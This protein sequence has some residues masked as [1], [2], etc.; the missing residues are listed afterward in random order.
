MNT[1][2]G[3]LKRMVALITLTL[4]LFAEFSV[5]GIVLVS[6]AIDNFTSNNENVELVAYFE[7]EDGEKSN[8]TQCEIN[9][10]KILK[11]DVTL[12]NNQGY[13]GYFEGKIQISNAN[14]KFIDDSNEE[15]HLSAGET[16]TIEKQICYASIKNFNE[17]Y[18]NK[19]T[20]INLDGKYVNSKG[21]YDIQEIS[22]VKVN[23]ISP[24][25]IDSNFNLEV[26]TNTTYEADNVQD[27]NLN[28]SEN[29][30]ETSKIKRILQILITSGVEDDIYPAKHRKV[31][32]YIPSGV[33]SISIHE[34]TN[35][36]QN[37]SDEN[38][39]VNGEK[40]IIDIDEKEW[41]QNELVVT[42]IF[43]DSRDLKGINI[44]GKLE[45]ILCDET[46]LV[47][48]AEIEIQNEENGMV[49]GQIIEKEE[50]IG[51]GKIYSDD[52]RIYSSAT[53]IR[54]DCANATDKVTI[55]EL[56]ADFIQND[57][58][59]AD[60]NIEFINSVV[61]KKEL[62]NIFGE[63][64]FINIKDQ[65]ENVIESINNNSEA[66]DNECITI[67]YKSGV[68]QISIETSTPKNNGMFYIINNKKIKN[69]ILSR[70]EIAKL[71][72]L[73][74]NVK[75]NNQIVKKDIMLKETETNALVAIEDSNIETM[76]EEKQ[77]LN[78][79]IKLDTQDEMKNLYKKPKVTITM[80]EEIK[81]IVINQAKAL[82]RNGLEIKSANS[83]KN[84]EGKCEIV[85]E[86][87]GEQTN[88]DNNGGLELYLY[89]NVETDNMQQSTTSKILVTYTNELTEEVKFVEKDI[90]FEAKYKIVD[91]P[92]ENIRKNSSN[93]RSINRQTPQGISANITAMREN[94]ELNEEST[95]FEGET[96]KYTVEITNNSDTNYTNLNIKAIQTN[97]KMW[98]YIERK[99]SNPHYGTTVL[100]NYYELT[101][102]NEKTFEKISTFNI[103]DTITLEYEAAADEVENEGLAT[104]GTIIVTADDNSLNEQFITTENEIKEAQLKVW[105]E[106]EESKENTWYAGNTA[107]YDLKIKN[108]KDEKI[109]NA[110]IQLIF[111]SNQIV[112]GNADYIPLGQY[113]NRITFDET[114]KSSN[115]DTIITL[116]IS[117][118]MPN[119]EILIFAHSKMNN[120]EDSQEQDQVTL[121]ARGITEENTY[122]SNKFRRNF[123]RAQNNIE[124]DFEGFKADG[125]KVTEN[126]VFE[127]GDSI[128]LVGT[129]TNNENEDITI[130]IT[131]SLNPGL[132]FEKILIQ[133][134][135]EQAIELTQYATEKTF[136]DTLEI[137]A[138]SQ[139]KI[140][141][142]AKINTD[143]LYDGNVSNQLQIT[144]NRYLKVYTKNIYFNA[145]KITSY[146]PE[147]EEEFDESL[148]REPT[149]IENTEDNN[150]ESENQKPDEQKPNEQNQNEQETKND[151]NQNGQKPNVDKQYNI[152][153]NIWID[154]NE[155]GKRDPDEEKINGIKVGA[156]NVATGK[157]ADSRTET[158][159]YG[160]YNLKLEKGKYIII[161]LYDTDKYTT[162]IYQ[163][164]GVSDSYNSDAVTRN[165]K[166]KDIITKVGATDQID[167][168]SDLHNIDLGLVKKKTFK[169]ELE[170]SVKKIIVTN[171]QGNKTYDYDDVKLAKVEI[172]TK[173]LNGTNITIIY[174]LKIKNTGDA[175]GI[176]NGIIDYLPS[177]MNF[178]SSLNPNWYEKDGKL[179]NKSL[180]DTKMKPEET[181][182]IELIVTRTMTKSNTELVENRAEIEGTN[183]IVKAEAMLGISTGALVNYLTT[184]VLTT[185]AICIFAYII[186][187]KYLREKM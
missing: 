16:K 180:S 174:S 81:N 65:D 12:K 163:A 106:D 82:Y 10:N 29:N 171:K 105:I 138:N 153:G 71:T 48:N 175:E 76:T 11:I 115:G 151:E 140:Y 74:E 21:E 2:K 45:T 103:G 95:I 161:F 123:Y 33:E 34:R 27:K 131:D 30:V 107:Y 164:T 18:L 162:T 6:Y 94:E 110:Q 39:I 91:E 111:S 98:D 142:S 187:K 112:D 179:Y 128:T 182:E 8:E 58:I 158:D 85:L 149:I 7:T 69:T 4:I 147:Y 145:N 183:N 51:K 15:I 92:E 22:E 109:E 186:Y 47:R 41:K 118:I 35:K 28:D 159:E 181:R 168:A 55:N 157:I 150:E 49:T 3:I 104:Y 1:A 120:I 38:Y 114:T 121:N 102:N 122:I 26:L 50:E 78:L 173:Y 61:S 75:I 19:K 40:L 73:R 132:T 62:T 119:E 136:T 24:K 42:Y 86:F 31:E 177:G 127:N 66:N 144:D 67:N 72:A 32:L 148:V 89:I 96:I 143:E 135:N 117:E 170:K 139:I 90:N 80:P 53:Q 97:G 99:V 14:F 63:D 68:S 79:A 64:W 84:A 54:V 101:D 160:T 166:E 185:S 60:A 87:D 52:E 130:T 113:A 165:L 137:P 176:V 134:E 56:G 83:Y 152:S 129:V 5:T 59:V 141:I 9:Q 133:K 36:E 88:Y 155:N 17:E 178:N 37:I 154:T 57:E 77:F 25:N 124:I 169:P 13:G 126:T 108:L 100:Q 43:E 44:S 46:N 70:E 184:T 20:T 167:I 93:L 146:E 156:V 116:N 172:P 23:W 125:N